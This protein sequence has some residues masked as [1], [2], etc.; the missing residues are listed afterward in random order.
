MNTLNTFSRLFC[1]HLQSSACCFDCTLFPE[2]QK[3]SRRP[4]FD[5][6]QGQRF[7]SS[8][9]VQTSWGQPILLSSR[10]WV[11]SPKGQTRPGPDADHSPPSSAELSS[12][13]NRDYT[14]SLSPLLTISRRVKGQFYVF[15]R[16]INTSVGNWM[17][18]SPED[19]GSIFLRT[20]RRLHCRENLR[21]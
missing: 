17:Q 6:R 21:S 3:E 8:H 13:T 4:G 11:I 12:R 20:H 5:F 9:R 18:T 15:D 19:G 16:K 2:I 14:P 7:F 10:Y 1:A